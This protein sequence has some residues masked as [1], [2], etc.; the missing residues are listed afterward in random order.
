MQPDGQGTGEEKPGNVVDAGGAADAS[1]EQAN[2][3][4]TPTDAAPTDAAPTPD[5]TETEVGTQ[6]GED[7]TDPEP[8]P[9][10]GGEM[11]AAELSD[12]G[13]Q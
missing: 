3:T 5:T 10:Q 4:A 13:Q 2:T 8:E 1:S 7:D 12:Q 6:H 9:E 11:K